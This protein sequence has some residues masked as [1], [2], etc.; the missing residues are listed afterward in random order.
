[1]TTNS[2]S[3]E[4]RG[5]FHGL[6]A[7][8]T[9][10][11]AAVG[12]ATLL[13]AC[14]VP[15]ATSEESTKPTMAVRA[16]SR[17]EARP[18][19][20]SAPQTSTPQPPTST[21]EPPTPTPEPSTPTPVP[22]TP[23][24]EP[25]SPT[26]TPAPDL[27][28]MVLKTVNFRRYATTLN[29][30]PLGEALASYSLEVLQKTTDANAMDWYRGVLEDAE[31]NLVYEDPVWIANVG[32]NNL[33][34]FEDMAVE[35]VEYDALEM[36]PVP[37]PDPS[38]GPRP[39]VDFEE[40]LTYECMVEC[41]VNLVYVPGKKTKTAFYAPPVPCLDGTIESNWLKGPSPNTSTLSILIV[42]PPDMECVPISEAAVDILE[43][44]FKNVP[45][46]EA[47]HEREDSDFRAVSD[48]GADFAYHCGTPRNLIGTMFR[49]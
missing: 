49:Y 29:N 3:K 10:V 25:P 47:F 19:N 46:P 4:R 32:G 15:T 5:A 39:P 27:E 16:T 30:N 34:G 31:G 2:A 38:K 44:Y 18:T 20:D 36:P 11:V 23:T 43:R 35:V 22:P 45:G 13:A 6:R 26:P 24:P 28:A 40:Y 1:M 14:V 37:T 42:L 12:L 48:S 21:P 9:S 7:G 41:M 33:I 17:D 8:V